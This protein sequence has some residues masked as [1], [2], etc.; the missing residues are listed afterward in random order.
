[1][2]SR[3]KVF[4]QGPEQ[5][6]RKKFKVF[7]QGG[8]H[9]VEGDRWLMVV[10]KALQHKIIKGNHDA[11]TIGHMGLNKIMDHIKRAFGGLIFGA[12]WENTCDPIRAVNW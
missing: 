5:L 7:P 2:M 4:S 10:P 6:Q 9:C 12:P 11:P 3:K 8:L 1:M